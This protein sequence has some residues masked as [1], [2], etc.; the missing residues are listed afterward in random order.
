MDLLL[1]VLLALVIS[2]TYRSENMQNGTL[3]VKTTNNLK[4]LS[5]MVIILH[6]L[7]QNQLLRDGQT[8]YLVSRFLVAGRL[9]VAVFFFVSGYGIM[10]QLQ[11]KG[12]SYLHGFIG[13]RVLPICVDYLVVMVIVFFIKNY[14]YGLTLAQAVQSIFIGS[15]F[16]DDSWFI[17]AIIIFYLV[18]WIAALMR[19]IHPLLFP[20][21]NII[22]LLGYIFGL[23]A[24][25][26]GEWWLNAAPVFF[27]GIF[28]ADQ[29]AR[30]VALIRTYY[31]QSLLIFP[32]LFGL[33]FTAD[34]A[35]NFLLIRSISVMLFVIVVV[36][37][38]YRIE[39]HHSIFELFSKL[40]LFIYLVHGVAL[41][42]LVT[43]FPNIPFKSLSIPVLLL[44]V[45]VV[46]ALI[47]N[48][49]LGFVVSHVSLRMS[50][51]N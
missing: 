39:I 13:H 26:F 36:L 28:W 6:H 1:F 30:L 51:K 43:Q 18:F 37:I 11:I 38:S 49:T 46:L 41:N 7:S 23:H 14:V 29:E 50:S 47:L 34:E 44:F 5:L 17:F 9:A 33:F 32:I 2:N 8:L 27:L 31:R 16:V 25:G 15:P 45:S 35:K 4:G 22:G 21:I 24:I 3:S 40:S 20:I 48:K 12:K 42:I 10:R 19:T